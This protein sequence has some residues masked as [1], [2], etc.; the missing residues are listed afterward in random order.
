MSTYYIDNINGKEEN[1][2]LSPEAAKS[3]LTELG[4]AE[5]DTVLFKCGNVYK[6]MLRAELG[7]AYGSYGEGEKPTFNPSEDVS[8]PE[9]WIETDTPNVWQCIQPV[10]GEVGNFIFNGDECTATLRWTREE[11]S[12]QGDF[13]DS[14]YTKKTKPELEQTLLMYSLGNPGTVYRSIEAASYAWRRCANVKGNN[15]IENLCF[16][17]SGVHGLNGSCDNVTIRNCDFLNIGG[18]AWSLE[19]KVRFGNAIEFWEYGNNILVEGC[20]FKNIYD[21]CVTHQGPGEKTV[22]TT[23]FNCINNVF[24]T[25][26]MAAF[27]YRDKMTVDS[28]FRGNTCKGAGSGF[29]MLGEGDPRL[30]EIYPEPMGHHIFLWRIDFPTEGG[31]LIIEN[32][33][34]EDATVGAA[35]YS[36]ISPEAEAQITL[37]NNRYTR[38][39][40]LLVRFGGENYVSLEE[41]KAST[42]KDSGSE[43]LI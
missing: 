37:C 23:R 40:R 32:N 3:D 21:S 20:Y 43:Y 2:G 7:V 28:V 1:D 10:C 6:A 12:G 41:Y 15:L 31:G 34:F 5:G 27:E 19:L 35:I 4:L 42:G 26:G 24:D 13:W 29:A 36:R 22:P 17:N 25:Y 39:E 11:L 18:C 14:R 30:S 33:T 9:A 16:K 38:N 8:S